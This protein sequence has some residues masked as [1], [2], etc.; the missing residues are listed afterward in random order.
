MLYEGDLIARIQSGQIVDV[1][2]TFL[3]GQGQ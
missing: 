2:D 3:S 1:A